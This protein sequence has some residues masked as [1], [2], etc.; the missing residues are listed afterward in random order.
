MGVRGLKVEN[1]KAADTASNLGF[2]SSDFQISNLLTSPVS[3][4]GHIC[5]IVAKAWQAK[6]E[7]CEF[8]TNWGYIVYCWLVLYQ[9][10]TQTRVI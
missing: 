4:V 3:A 9:L 10:D 1:G 8:E 7:D 6:Q 2:S 5:K